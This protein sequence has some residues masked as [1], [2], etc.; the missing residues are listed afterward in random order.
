LPEEFL[1]NLA[2]QT[3]LQE[4]TDLELRVLIAVRLQ[5]GVSVRIKDGPDLHRVIRTKLDVGCVAEEQATILKMLGYGDVE[6][7]RQLPNGHVFRR[8][9]GMVSLVE[10]VVEYLPA[11]LREVNDLDEDITDVVCDRSRLHHP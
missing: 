11:K 7:L 1:G 2:V 9:T 10:I 8:E 6:R 4:L 5:Q 3:V